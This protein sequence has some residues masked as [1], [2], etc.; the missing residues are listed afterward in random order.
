MN[1]PGWGWHY[2]PCSSNRLAALAVAVAAVVILAVLRP[3]LTAIVD[4][5]A[6]TILSVCALGTVAVAR[7]IWT[8]RVRHARPAPAAE[9]AAE[10]PAIAP[11]VV[12]GEVLASHYADRPREFRERTRHA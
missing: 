11:R 8:G 12:P 7:L 6:I 4:I 9:P 5:A 2:T 1:R 3:A 10:W